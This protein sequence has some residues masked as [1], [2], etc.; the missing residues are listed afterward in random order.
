VLEVQS[1][2]LFSD[3]NVLSRQVEVVV[4]DAKQQTVLFQ[5]MPKLIKPED[6][7]VALQLEPLEDVEAARNTA[8]LIEL[9]DARTKEILDTQA[10]TLLV[11][12][13]NW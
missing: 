9:R 8:L 12:L 13:E 1:E 5:G 3:N 6:R 4:Y 11:A 10:S 2:G 7:S